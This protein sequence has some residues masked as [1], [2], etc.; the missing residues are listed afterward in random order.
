VRFAIVSDIHANVESLEAVFAR[1]PASD[2][3]LCLGDTV[4]YGPNPNECLALV[5][6]RAQATVLGNHD[7]AA[8]DGFGLEYFNDAARVAIE[9]T[10]SVIEPGHAAWLDALS[11]EIRRDDYL[12]VHGAPVDY[13]TYILDKQ[14]A[15]N[16]FAATD[17]PLIFVGHT[18]LADYYALSPDGSI[19]H[20]FRQNGGRLDLESGVRYIVNA[21]SVGQPR[22][23]NPDASFATF[24]A[25]ARSVV[26]ERVPY[27][28]GRTQEKIEAAC[29]PEVL[30]RRLER[31][32]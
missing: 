29:L 7:V 20:A 19:A 8:V 4:G 16:A 15:A 30:A 12:M 5:R 17:A 13:F 31:G 28:V 27:A 25:E 21:G 32:R 18:H 10:R 2:A 22:D 14:G 3:V 26:W 1:I 11:Y 6:E 23:L 9:W 24:D